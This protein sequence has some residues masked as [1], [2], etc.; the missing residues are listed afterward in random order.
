MKKWTEKLPEAIYTRLCNCKIRKEDI[1]TL[2]NAKW[3]AY[4]EE[5]KEKRGFTKEDALI[6]ILELLE[7]NSTIIDLTEEEYNELWR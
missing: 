3:G 1:Q 6:A 2:V 4:K 7:C 5:G